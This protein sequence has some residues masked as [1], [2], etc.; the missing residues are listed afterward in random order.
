MAS[1]KM[2]I[3]EQYDKVKALLNGE[4]VEDYT[5]EQA[6]QFLT[7]R[8]DQTA[9]KNANR[10]TDRKPTPK[11]LAK[12][13]E[14]EKIYTEIGFLLAT[15]PRMTITEM[16]KNSALLAELSNQKVSAMLTDMVDIGNV[17]RTKDKGKTYFSLSTQ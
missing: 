2:T 7:E 8:A 5:I 13:A 16:Q 9:K 11:E 12:Q 4:V 14:N 10:G 15:T 17:V 3:I 1:K 6:L